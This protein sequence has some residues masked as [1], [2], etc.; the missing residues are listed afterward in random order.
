MLDIYSSLI[1]K[2]GYK[3]KSYVLLEKAS[4]ICYKNFNLDFLDILLAATGNALPC[5]E[6]KRKRKGGTTVLVPFPLKTQRQVF[7]SVNHI[8]EG[9][10]KRTDTCSSL[11]LVKE[12]VDT[13]L[14]L[15]FSYK[16]RQN[17]D[18]KAE[19]NRAYAFLRWN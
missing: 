16:V 8:L 10:F 14:G 15:S 5:F 2:K 7:L 18:K 12:L 17:L 4:F 9:A 3:N 6:T 19:I 1:I 11:A 13:V